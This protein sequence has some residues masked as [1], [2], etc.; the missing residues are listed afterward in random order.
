MDLYIPSFHPSRKNSLHG[1]VANV[2]DYDIIVNE[3]KI[4][5]YNYAYFQTNTLGKGMNS[6]IPPAMG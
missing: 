2:L 1:V 6:L 4:Q 5:S 3:F